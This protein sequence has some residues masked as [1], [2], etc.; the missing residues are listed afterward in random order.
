L[1]EGSADVYVSR[2]KSSVDLA[3]DILALWAGTQAEFGIYGNRPVMVLACLRRSDFNNIMR[4]WG[5]NTVTTGNLVDL[6]HLVWTRGGIVSS[7]YLLGTKA[8]ILRARD[9]MALSNVA[10]GAGGELFGP[11]DVLDSIRVDM[12]YASWQLRVAQIF[13]VVMLDG[14]R[15]VSIP[16]WEEMRNIAIYRGIEL[17]ALVDYAS[18]AT[19]GSVRNLIYFPGMRD[20]EAC[21]RLVVTYLVNI[22]RV[23]KVLLL[24]FRGHWYEEGQGDHFNG[25]YE[26]IVD[27]GIRRGANPDPADNNVW[28]I[29]RR[30]N[31]EGL[32]TREIKHPIVSNL[33][34]VEQSRIERV[35]RG[36]IISHKT[37]KVEMDRIVSVMRTDTEDIQYTFWSTIAR[38]TFR[39]RHT[40]QTVPECYVAWAHDMDK[41]IKGE[42]SSQNLHLYNA[43]DR[44]IG[45][46]YS[47]ESTAGNMP[48]FIDFGGYGGH[49][50]LK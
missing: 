7:G 34:P 49:G 26:T 38:Q 30:A 35:G 41:A 8:D 15:L 24:G 12:P 2:A 4:G 19:I 6:A 39:I 40:L 33:E 18:Q 45:V 43:F 37:H 44:N 25:R 22:I 27:E 17:G 16:F 29:E 46:R 32:Q 9:F 5:L 21:F 13:D 36:G 20:P 42:I 11:Y 47:S 14:D 48:G 1:Q 10:V 31:W 23:D 28:W 3:Q 50:N